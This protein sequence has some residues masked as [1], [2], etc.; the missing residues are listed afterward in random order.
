M[1]LFFREYGSKGP[2]LVI[3]HGLY[4]ASDNWVSIARQLENNYHVYL[5]D[6]RNHGQSP[7][8]AS[9][10]YADMA[11]DLLEFFTTHSIEKAHV[12]GHSMGGKTAMC[13][14]LKH[15]QLID[16]LVVLDIAPKSYASFSNYAQITNNHLLIIQSMLAVDFEHV[17]SRHD[18]D[19][20]MSQLLPE[21]QLRQ[22]LLK[23]V[24]RQKDGSYTWRLNLPALQVNLEKIMDGLTE[25]D[26]QPANIPTVFIRG[27]ES[28]YVMDEDMLL[29]RKF[30]PGSELV[31]IPKAGHWLHAQQPELLIKTLNYFLLD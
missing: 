2:S 12:V 13:F 18:V 22:F 17:K 27:D 10:T 4:G 20:Q 21:K 6:Q 7:H 14:A 25:Q 23:N 3:I 15:P 1:K 24:E 28:G 16:K 8:D 19:A 5:I 26:H 11:A 31:T 29:A 9:H 30:F